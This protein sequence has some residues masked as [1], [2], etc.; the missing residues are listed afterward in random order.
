MV[1]CGRAPHPTKRG[2]FVTRSGHFGTVQRMV[3]M[4]H[5]GGVRG[6]FWCRINS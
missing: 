4:T 5:K 3:E 1:G 2:V 6:L